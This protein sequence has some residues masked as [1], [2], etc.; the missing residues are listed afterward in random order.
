MHSDA[1]LLRAIG[2]SARPE[3]EAA[4]SACSDDDWSSEVGGTRQQ[5]AK[6][7]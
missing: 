1:P 4:D 5:L 3:L 6:P 2:S 7:I